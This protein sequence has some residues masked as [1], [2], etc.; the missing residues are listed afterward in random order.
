MRTVSLCLLVACAQAADA[1][2]PPLDPGPIVV[3]VCGDLGEAVR[4]HAVGERRTAEGLWF[5]AHERFTGEL[6]PWLELY[7]DEGTAV[8]H[9]YRL[10]RVRVE[11]TRR[12]G[13]PS[14]PVASLCTDLGALAPAAVEAPPGV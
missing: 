14:D 7:G 2:P 5:A 9:A 10:G 1:P 8:R 11:L 12:R 13:N 3:E 6:G 4:Q